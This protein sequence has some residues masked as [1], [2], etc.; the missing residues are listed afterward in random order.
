MTPNLTKGYAQNFEHGFTDL[1]N[2]NFSTQQVVLSNYLIQQLHLNKVS[3]RGMQLFANMDS[4]TRLSGYG[5]YMSKN[6]IPVEHF[7]NI[8]VI[9]DQLAIKYLKDSVEELKKVRIDVYHYVSGSKRNKK[10]KQTIPLF[11]ELRLINSDHGKGVIYE[12]NHIVTQM[13]ENRLGKDEYFKLYAKKHNLSGD[14][15]NHYHNLI[16]DDLFKLCSLDYGFPLSEVDDY[17]ELSP[18]E[19]AR[20]F[21]SNHHLIEQLDGVDSNAIHSSSQQY[22]YFTKILFGTTQCFECLHTHQMH[23][24]ILSKS[25]LEKER[26]I[27]AAGNKHLISIVTA[28]E[29]RE[30]LGFEKPIYDDNYELTLALNK[31]IKDLNKYSEKN[32]DLKKIKK[33][34]NRGL[35]AQFQLTIS[36]KSDSEIK[37]LNEVFKYKNKKKGSSVSTEFKLLRDFNL[38]LY[39]VTNDGK[40]K[41][42]S[43]PLFLEIPSKAQEKNSSKNFFSTSNEKY[44]QAHIDPVEERRE[45][46]ARL[47]QGK[48]QNNLIADEESSIKDSPLASESDVLHLELTDNSMLLKSSYSKK[49]KKVTLDLRGHEAVFFQDNNLLANSST[50]NYELSRDNIRLFKQNAKFLRPNKKYEVTVRVTYDDSNIVC[51]SILM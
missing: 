20:Q 32:V 13:I 9:Q 47:A 42:L 27:D 34:G 12:F 35:S 40:V 29:L 2:Y 45:L 31:L 6:F 19:L 15:Y 3:N 17:I 16:A 8:Q 43:K 30:A 18:F 46:R 44:S 28:Q 5:V 14:A 4:V 36:D 10:V 22:K 37:A 39:R 24:Y 21:E 25:T 50:F 23:S 51:K 11:K 26:Y 38:K 7:K 41:I 33:N 1:K 48:G 49:I